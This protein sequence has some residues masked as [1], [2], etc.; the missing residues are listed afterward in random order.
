LAASGGGAQVE[1]SRK[2][3]DELIEIII[4]NTRRI[5]DRVRELAAAIKG[6]T[7][8]PE[9]SPADF[10][11]CGSRDRVLTSVCRHK[12]VALYAEGLESLSLIQADEHRLFN[13]LYNVIDN[14]IPE[15]PAGGSVTVRGQVDVGTDAL[16]ISVA[17]YGKRDAP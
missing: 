1:V 14:A 5:Q 11:V 7:T 4:N 15:V 13:V 6:V 2:V 16:V 17:R 9:F 12:G 3:S 8:A 10:G